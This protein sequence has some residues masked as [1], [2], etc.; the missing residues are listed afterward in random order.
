M[1]LASLAVSHARASLLVSRQALLSQQMLL[2]SPL[3]WRVQAA[4]PRIG[5][6]TLQFEYCSLP[7]QAQLRSQGAHQPRPQAQSGA[8][9]SGQAPSSFGPDA[10]AAASL[11]VLQYATIV[12]ACCGVAQTCLSRA[13]RG[14]ANAFSC[15]P[16]PSQNPIAACLNLPPAFTERALCLVTYPVNAHAYKA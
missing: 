15:S 2:A 10:R 7:G 1:R 11:A 8:A 14:Q 6:A 3:L 4:L 12:R 16:R 13:S 5:P 9:P